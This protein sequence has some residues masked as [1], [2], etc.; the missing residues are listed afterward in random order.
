MA[1][2]ATLQRTALR[3]AAAGLLTLGAA[4]LAPSQAQT[5]PAAAERAALLR[6]WSYSLA[7]QAATWG[8]PLVT[9]YQLRY[10]DAVGPKAKAAPNSVWR[11]V[12]ISTPELSKEAGYVTPNVNVIYGF[13][14]LDLRQQP[15]ILDVPDSNERYYM[16]EIVDMWTNAFAYVGGNATGY[17]GGKVALVGPGWKGTLPPGVRRIDCLT[18][19]VLIQPRVHLY[20]DGKVDL[21]G[22]RKILA[23][24]TPIGLAQYLG[25]P[26][27]AAPSYDY[28]APDAVDPNLPV[29]VLSFK[30][31]LQFWE[32][33]AAAMTENP[34]PKDEIA[35]LLPMF[36]PLG[37]EL[38]KPWD[39]RKLSP[40]VLAAMSEAATR[41]GP[42]LAKIPAG[43]LDHFAFIPP[44]SIGNFGTDYLTRAVVA[45]TGLTANTPVEAVYWGY[46]LDAEGHPL[47]GDRKYTLTF[48]SDIPYDKP[49]FW[50]IT[51]YDSANNYTVANPINRYMLGS[52]SRD[53]KKNPDGSFTIYIQ[54]DDPGADKK[55][56]WL[57]APP[58][59]F[60][61]IPRAYVPKPAAMNLLADPSAWPVPA[62]VPVP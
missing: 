5:S 35:A 21:P 10:H 1:M 56:N 8:G 22:A 46:V 6:E 42:M 11:M 50:S 48:A 47:S 23:A 45:R 49:G 2:T 14:F 58:G 38:G 30:D 4:A 41:I 59:P 37:I 44:P 33:L 7:L 9:M 29:S 53:M 57:P 20:V 12:D 32:L 31:P 55:G 3:V 62:V 17:K 60:Y 51:M 19:W 16:V 40:P 61:L 27:P 54:K 15:I 39:R 52:D 26:A 36:K 43:R 18:P 28:A 13:G 24:I 25:K 34:P